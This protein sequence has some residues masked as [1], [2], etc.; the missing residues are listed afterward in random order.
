MNGL[1]FCNLH[2]YGVEKDEA[3]GF[4]FAMKAAERGHAASQTLVGECYLD[5]LGVERNVERG[6]VWLY[7]A[8]RQNNKRA[9]MLLRSR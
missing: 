8:A 6:E 2:G 7:R 5:G 9:E 1:A 3:K 4:E